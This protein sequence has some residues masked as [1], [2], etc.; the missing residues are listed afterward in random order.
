M[1][2]FK[3]PPQIFRLVL[4][5]IGIVVS[6][7]I[8]RQLLTPPSFREFG[9][10]RGDALEEMASRTPVFAGRKSCSECHEDQQARL[11]K[12]EHK[13]IGCETCHGPSSAHV[14]DP[15]SEAKKPD[16]RNT[17]A[18]I[19]CHESNPSRPA[20]FRQINVKNHYSDQKCSEC[21]VPHQPNEVP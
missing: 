10:Y 12:G 6:Y 1:G 7:L 4:L 5:T 19:R 16:K 20:W 11:L 14:A 3:M 17:T 9:F 2:R 8:A 15:D 21:H 18:C 13:T